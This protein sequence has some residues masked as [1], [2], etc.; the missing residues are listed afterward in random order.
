MDFGLSFWLFQW[1]SFVVLKEVNFKFCRFS[2]YLILVDW[3]KLLNGVIV[4]LVNNVMVNVVLWKF[5][6]KLVDFEV[7]VVKCRFCSLEFLGGNS[8]VMDNYLI[9]VQCFKCCKDLSWV[10]DLSVLSRCFDVFSF[11]SDFN[12][13]LLEFCF[14]ENNNV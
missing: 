1:S 14:D 10:F 4:N 7:M 13:F 9:L 3:D 12:C 6:Q 5:K 8:D 2:N 11:I